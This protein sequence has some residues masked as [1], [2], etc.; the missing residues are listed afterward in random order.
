M[1]FLIHSFTASHQP[2][3]LRVCSSFQTCLHRATQRCTPPGNRSEHF[4][5][6]FEHYR[7]NVRLQFYRNLQLLNMSPEMTS[8]QV[9]P[10]HDYWYHGGARA[11]RENIEQIYLQF[12]QSRFLNIINSTSQMLSSSNLNNDV[13]SQK[14]I[15]VFKSVSIVSEFVQHIFMYIT[16]S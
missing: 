11:R 3:L 8:H 12:N 6:F 1:Q 15:I 16:V 13:C 14:T 9:I 4:H 2:G 5:M 7:L 10:S